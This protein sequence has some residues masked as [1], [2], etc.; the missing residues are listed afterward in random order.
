MCMY[1]YVKDN[2]G[3]DME[4]VITQGKVRFEILYIIIEIIL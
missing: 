2:C 4:K 3:I 1:V